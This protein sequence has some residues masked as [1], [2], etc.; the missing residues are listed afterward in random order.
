MPQIHD[1]IRHTAVAA[2]GDVMNRKNAFSLFGYDIMVDEYF[3]VR[4]VLYSLLLWSKLKMS[5]I[6]LATRADPCERLSSI[7]PAHYFCLRHGYWRSTQAQHWSTAQRSHPVSLRKYK[8]T[9]SR[10]CLAARKFAGRIFSLHNFWDSSEMILHYLWIAALLL[11]LSYFD[12]C[13][14]R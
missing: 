3:N 9:L 2:Q 6:P 11:N 7:A 10:C 14:F 13:C 8:R 1:I 4:T 5:H 12:F